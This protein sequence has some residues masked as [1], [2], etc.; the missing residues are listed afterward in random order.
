MGGDRTSHSATR[1]TRT[2]SLRDRFEETDVQT[3]N[4]WNNFASSLQHQ[5]FITNQIFSNTLL[6]VSAYETTFNKDD[7]IYTNFFQNNES[8]QTIV[9]TSPLSNKS[10]MNRF[11]LNQTFDFPLGSLSTKAGFQ[12]MYHRGEYLEESF[13]RPRFFD[14]TTSFQ[15]DVF[16][17]IDWQASAF[18]DISAGFRAHHYTNGSYIK[19]SPRLSIR[20]FNDRMLSLHA[21]FSKNHQF[22]NRISFKNAVTADL[23]I[24][25]DAQQPPT[26]A[27]QLTAG[28]E[29]KPFKNVLIKTDVYNKQYK[30]LRL[31]ELNTTSLTNTLSETPWYFQNNG[32]AAGLESLIRISSG[33][34]TLT[35]THTLSSI[36]LQNDL[37]NNGEVFY[38]PWDRRHSFG[39]LLELPVTHN[40]SVFASYTAASGTIEFLPTQQSGTGNRLPNYHRL[41]LS[42]AYITEFDSKKAS[43]KFSVFNVTDRQNTWYREYQP[44]IFTRQTIPA[45]RAEL[46]DVFD[47]GIQPS[48]EIK[49]N[50]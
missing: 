50:F 35:Q 44:V 28:V 9:F 41:D 38:A 25:A 32:E 23:W 48:F 27:G 19:G 2:N 17:H 24:L 43:V 6:G 22:I 45:I 33:V 20:L 29:F 7:F 49:L 18:L 36:K 15:T 8:F 46:V 5:R 30:N 13:D 26:S 42:V 1:I 10:T 40:L 34:L 37:L 39:T 12:A 47:L 11:K 16:A 4:R 31:H 3:S 14:K 21:G